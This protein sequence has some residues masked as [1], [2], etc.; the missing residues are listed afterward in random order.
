MNSVEFKR[1]DFNKVELLKTRIILNHGKQTKGDN[2]IST[3]HIVVL[4]D[5]TSQTRKSLKT[6]FPSIPR[7][8]YPE[9]IQWRAIKN[10]AGRDFTITEQSTIVVERM[11]FKH[12][13]FLQDLCTTDYRHLQKMSTRKLKQYHSY[14]CHRF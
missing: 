1:F 13:T 10:T 2:K 9:D 5:K 4:E 7:Q 3:I 12:N 14:H 6:I 8:N 11:R